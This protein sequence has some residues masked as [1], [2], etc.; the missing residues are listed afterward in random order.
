IEMLKGLRDRYEAH[1][2][3]TI[4]DPAIAAA[5][6][7]ADR[8]INDRFLPD[9]A[10]DLIDEAGARLRIRRMTAPPELKEFDDKIAQVRLEK[11]SAIDGQ[12]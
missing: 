10:I 6:T 2:K 12:D 9:K 8:Y 3:V 5:V 4:T 1:H 11:E 7:M